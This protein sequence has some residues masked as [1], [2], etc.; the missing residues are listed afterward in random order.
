MKLRSQPWMIQISKATKWQPQHKLES[1]RGEN[2][3]KWYAKRGHTWDE[4]SKDKA[5]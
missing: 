3:R 5:S 1:Q 2:T 4:C